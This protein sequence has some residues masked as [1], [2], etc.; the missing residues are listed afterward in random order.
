MGTVNSPRTCRRPSPRPS[1][2]AASIT[3]HSAR[4]T[5]TR[6]V[7]LQSTRSRC[8][9]RP[10]GGTAGNVVS[11]SARTASSSGSNRRGESPVFSTRT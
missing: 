3:T 11:P 5:A 9:G 4:A 7:A 10:C 6:P 8:R 2:A 1:R